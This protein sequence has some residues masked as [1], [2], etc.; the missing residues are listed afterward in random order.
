[1]RE[2]ESL[3][4]SFFPLPDL[5]AAQDAPGSEPLPRSAR[6]RHARCAL[7]GRMAPQPHGP[8]SPHGPYARPCPLPSMSGA[9]P[10]PARSWA[11]RRHRRAHLLTRVAGGVC[12]AGQ[13]GATLARTRTKNKARVGPGRDART[14]EARG[15]PCADPP[16][17]SR[18]AASRAA[19]RARRQAPA[20]PAVAVVIRGR[21]TSHSHPHCG[22]RARKRRN[23]RQT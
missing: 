23:R 21:P 6:P 12:C 4:P 17:S 22:M 15:A 5:D 10:G 20:G 8:Q 7:A 11:L 13:A 3:R 9:H 1:M 16:A 18:S 2:S 19:G 14:R